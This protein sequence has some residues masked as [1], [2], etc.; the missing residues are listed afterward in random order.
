MQILLPKR[1]RH[2]LT[3]Q[4]A[5]SRRD[6]I[7]VLMKY[8]H[9]TFLWH[10]A[11]QHLLGGLSELSDAVTGSLCPQSSNLRLMEQGSGCLLAL[12]EHVPGAACRTPL[13]PYS[14]LT[15][16]LL[17]DSSCRNASFSSRTCCMSAV[18]LWRLGGIFHQ[19]FREQALERVCLFLL[20]TKRMASILEFLWG[21]KTTTRLHERHVTGFCPPA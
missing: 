2:S 5:M 13:S 19:G 12:C 7:G 1:K 6:N 4:H 18:T 20:S 21:T 10:R 17:R 16:H 11:S 15:L 9:I 3:C 14:S 8:P